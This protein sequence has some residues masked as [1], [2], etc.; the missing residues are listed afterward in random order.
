MFKV[1]FFILKI[2]FTSAV[3]CAQKRQQ[4][5]KTVKIILGDIFFT[6]HF[7][8]HPCL[9]LLF[10]PIRTMKAAIVVILLAACLCSLSSAFSQSD[11]QGTWTGTYFFRDFYDTNNNLFCA[12]TMISQPNN[13]TVSGNARTSTYSSVCRRGKKRDS[14]KR[15]RW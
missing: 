7:A 13:F 15:E 4:T 1:S 5:E 8:S 6:P 3:D 10:S 14:E 9:F 2:H 11:L 12:T